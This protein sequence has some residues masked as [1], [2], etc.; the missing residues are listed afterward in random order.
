MVDLQTENFFGLKE[1]V[2]YGWSGYLLSK[3]TLAEV[4]PH[5]ARLY[6]RIRENSQYVDKLWHSDVVI[7][8][9]I[10]KVTKLLC[11]ESNGQSLIDYDLNIFKQHYEGYDPIYF[12]VTYHPLKSTED[13]I[14]YHNHV[15]QLS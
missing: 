1:T 11:W 3:S 12:S 8:K 14:E 2:L 10:T 4:I 5:F 6:K 13:M 9:C 7:S 15:R